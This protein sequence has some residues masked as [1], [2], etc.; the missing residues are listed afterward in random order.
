METFSSPNVDNMLLFYFRFVDFLFDVLNLSRGSKIIRF[1]HDPVL[2]IINLF[3]I[4]Y[5]D[6]FIFLNFHM[7]T[8]FTMP[9]KKDWR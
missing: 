2:S 6:P 4:K 9:T 3:I 7:Q 1:Y 8:F 5:I